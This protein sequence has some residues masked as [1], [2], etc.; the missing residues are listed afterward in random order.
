MRYL[1][2]AALVLCGLATEARADKFTNYGQGM[3]S[4][5][6]WLASSTDKADRLFF[7]TWILGWVSAAGYYDAQ[8]A[9]RETDSDA[10]AAWVD[11]YC[12]AHPLD[13]IAVAA[14]ALVTA[15]AKLPP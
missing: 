11:N 15:L 6:A 9:L 3:Q 14:A 1:V 8:G 4:C 13:H 10:I 12:H 2:I 7:T 5:G